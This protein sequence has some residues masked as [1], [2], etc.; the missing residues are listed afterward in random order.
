[1]GRIHLQIACEAT[2]RI[3]Q[4][5]HVLRLDAQP[6]AEMVVLHA[7]AEHHELVVLEQI[8]VG[9]QRGLVH[10]GLQHRTLVVQLEQ[11]QLAALAVDHAQI[12]H[13]AGQQLRLA[14][15]AQFTQRGTQEVAHLVLHLVE[16]VARQVKTHRQLFLRQA[17]LDAP[18]QDFGQGR[19]LGAGALGIVAHHVEQAALVGIRQLGVRVLERMVDRGHQRRAVQ[20]DA[21]EGPGLDQSLQRALVQLAAVHAR[22]EVAQALEGSLDMPV[23][24]H[25]LTF[26]RGD[27]GFDRLLARALDRAQAIANDLVRDGLKAVHAAVDVGHLEA[28]AHLQRIFVQH[29]EFVG[30]VHFHGHIPA[31]KFCRVVHLEPGR[32][33]GQQRI[34]GRVRLV[35]AVTR[36]FL[37]QVEHFT[38]LVLID[39]LLGRAFAEGGAVLDHLLHLLLAHGPAQQVGA[40]ERI[41]AQ[42]LGRLHHLLLVDHDAVGF[43]QHLLH[44]RVRVLDLLAPVLAR[45]EGRDQV[46]GAGTVQ[47][48]QR[49]QVFQARRLGVTQHALHAARFKLEHGLGLALLEQLVGR[50][51]VQGDFLETEV[52]LALVALHDEL[53]RD[54]QDGQR[55]QA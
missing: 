4:A 46:H 2:A 31:E 19:L 10:R 27:D 41:T 48:V 42:H 18:G 13:D 20:V 26:A 29:L 47:R 12:T 35:E 3:G 53:A 24:T 33:V 30:V 54:L 21:V 45:H 38:G 49:D 16:E 17:L 50:V 28:H 11:A 36:E 25:A 1:M 6:A 8:T 52:L 44:Q 37:H 55:G 51:V 34:G 22:T 5:E 15:V 7:A 32:V 23:R 39:A 40:A 9:I 43:G 14:T